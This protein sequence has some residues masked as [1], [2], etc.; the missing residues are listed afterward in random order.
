MGVVLGEGAHPGEPRGDAA[1]LVAV[2]PAEVAV[3]DRQVAVGAQP[4]LVDQAVG[5]AVHRLDR[6]SPLL[7]LGEEHR[8][9]VVVVVARG[10]PQVDVQDLR[11]HH[12]AVAAA[13]LQLAHVVD[14][15]VVDEPSL[16]VEEGARRRQR[17]EAEQVQLGPQLAVVAGLRRRQLLLVG[18][19]LGGAGEGGAVD[20][21]QHLVGGVALPVDAGG[22]EQL[23][24]A[25]LA[26]P[27]DV[28]PAAE[29]GERPVAV[30]GDRLALGDVLQPLD[31]EGLAH[32]AEQLG[33]LLAL[34]LEALEL[35]VLGEDLAHLGLD[36]LEVLGG[37]GAREAEV[38][39]ELLR[40]VLAADVDLDLRPQ[41]LDRVG[42]HVLGAV[43][44]EVAGLGVPRRQQPKAAAARQRLAQVD[45]LAVELG[46]DRRARQPGPD[47]RRHLERGGA[48]RHL[49]HRSVGKL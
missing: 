19:H 23:D 8:L 48:R 34:D 18:L 7:G 2:Q 5:R 3:A 46:A 35:V 20:P 44:D 22:L 26:Q 39:L 27:L 31:L 14:Q 16:G 24:G 4:R 45:R 10:V 11:R 36:P 13:V 37:E 9:A 40:V 32:L 21:L 30:E 43:A 25:D 42:Q 15:R 41:P 1:L 28:R 38:V 47:P 12:L 49:A 6:H 17:V 33:G 29:I